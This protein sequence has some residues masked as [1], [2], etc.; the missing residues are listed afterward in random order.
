MVNSGG[1]PTY[2][3]T[4]D[5]QF[6]KKEILFFLVVAFLFS[7]S[8][9][10]LVW[11]SITPDFQFG[12]RKAVEEL[13]GSTPMIYGFGPF[14]SAIITTLLFRSKKD[15]KALFRKV[16]EWRV[17]YKWYLVALFLPSLLQWL[18][19]LI[20]SYFSGTSV[21][22]PNMG[23][24]VSSWLGTGLLGATLYYIS[25]ELG[26]RGFLQP[27]FLSFKNVLKSTFIFGVIWSVWHYPL[28]ITSTWLTSGSVGEATLMVS[29]NTLLIISLTFFLT[30]IFKNTNGSILLAMLFHGASMASLAKIY[31]L[32]GDSA[33]TEPFFIMTLAAVF[34]VAALILILVTTMNR[35]VAE[36]DC[37]QRNIDA[38]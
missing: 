3:I 26:W 5:I 37:E 30:W 28:W 4:A 13:F 2:K 12:N 23:S 33:V 1:G 25:E 7:W 16:I 35:D 18:G 15:L 27:R 8:T 34:M 20:W 36:N 32:A 10:A 9:M 31:A 22:W 19:L 21:V 24:Y 38:G 17:S 29:S 14:I 6:L 11:N